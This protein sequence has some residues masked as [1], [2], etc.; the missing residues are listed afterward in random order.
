[1]QRAILL[2]SLTLVL[3]SP[4]KVTGAEIWVSPA[5]SDRN[6]GTRESPLATLNMAIRK[7]RELRR[8]NDPALKDGIRVIIRGGIYLLGEPVFIRPEDSGTPSSPTT[9]MA[10][11]GE[12]PVFSGGVKVTGWKRTTGIVPGLPISAKNKVWEAPAPRAGGH[13]LLTRQLWINNLKA[14]RARDRNT[15]SMSRI[16]SWDHRSQTCWIPKPKGFTSAGANGM[17]MLIQ[18]WW[19]TAVLRIKTTRIQ[20]DSIQLSFVEPEGRVQSEHPWPAPWISKKTGNSPFYLTNAIRFLDQPGEWF[21]D[22]ASQKIYYWPR[23]EENPATSSI[24]VPKLETLVKVTGTTDHPVSHLYFREISFEHTAWLRPSLTGSVPHQA[25]MYMLDAYKLE[26]P[27]TLDKKTLEN[28]AWVGR[29]AAGIELNYTDHTGFY[30]CRFRHMAATGL[31]YHR[32]NM[33]DEIKGNIFQDIG[34]TAIHAGVFSDESTEVHLPYNPS[35]ER[36]ITTKLLISNNLIQD[37]ANED[38][39]CVGIGAGYVRDIRIA[40]NEVS[41]VA[42][43]GISIGWG[44]TK[45][46]NA[47]KNNI[48]TANK[49]HHYARHLYD[50]AAIYTLSAQPASMITENYADSIYLAPYAHDPHHWFYLYCDEG[51]S[52]ITVKDN[53]CPSQKFLQNA[54]GPGNVWENNGPMVSADIKRNA[55][56]E[57]DYQ[58]LLQEKTVLRN[59]WPINHE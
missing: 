3:F 20:G 36:E 28:Q 17:E 16:L 6:I 38:W 11:P 51:S 27:G 5:G 13:L 35:N 34:G 23:P 26:I 40:H 22:E 30:G 15:D 12:H 10:A 7:A 52:Y 56:L 9:I 42:Y 43:T 24:I 31:D 39:G 49:I 21:L 2:F 48:I 19:A 44:W 37:A 18:Q 25:G 1:M 29:P 8:L 33:S 4:F 54:N 53:W 59:N 32:G 58:H 50:V 14:T 57:K 47:M 46:L 45:T 41:E 55:G